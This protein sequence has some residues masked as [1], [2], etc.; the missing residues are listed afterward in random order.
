[1]Y[2]IDSV[3]Q[4]IESHNEEDDPPDFLQQPIFYRF[5]GWYSYST[6]SESISQLKLLENEKIRLIIDSTYRDHEILKALCNVDKSRLQ[7][8]LEQEPD[9]N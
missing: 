4:E 5:D 6:W 9:S 2:S 8:I 7:V 3:T 1:M